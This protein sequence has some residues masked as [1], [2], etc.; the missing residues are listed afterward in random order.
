MRVGRSM[1]WVDG[2]IVGVH[3][4]MVAGVDDSLVLVDRSTGTEDTQK[5]Q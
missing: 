5:N 3:C 1:V 4:C 2:C